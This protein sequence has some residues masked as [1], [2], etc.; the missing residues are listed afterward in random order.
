MPPIDPI[1]FVIRAAVPD[2]VAHGL[3]LGKP[4]V[5]R[6][7]KISR[8][9]AHRG[10]KLLFRARQEL[11]NLILT[12]LPPAPIFSANFEPRLPRPDAAPGSA[13]A[14]H[15]IDLADQ[16]QRHQF[17]IFSTTIDARPDIRWRRDYLR[18]I[19]TGLEYF[20]LIPYL[21]T[22]RAGDHKTIW[23][24]NRHQHLLVLAQAHLLTHED[25]ALYW[26][27]VYSLVGPKLPGEFRARWLH[28]LYL[29][30]CHLANNLSFY[31]SPNNHLIGEA[32]ALHALARQ[33]PR[34]ERA[35]T[36]PSVSTT[37]IKPR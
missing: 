35:R 7:Q 18:G 17:P 10:V 6:S 37:A 16:I 25:G 20:R 19:E 31:F 36:I 8:Y 34:M 21:D 29:H 30:G 26:M 14:Q 11:V 12:A 1:A 33:V 15:M 3:D 4:G 9:S 5:S 13:Y 23:E 27:W 22:A 24:L 28:M 2:L 32:L